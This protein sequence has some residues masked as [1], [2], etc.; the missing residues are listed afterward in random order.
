MREALPFA[1]ASFPSIQSLTRVNPTENPLRRCFRAAS[2]LALATA[3]TTAV[4]TPLLRLQGIAYPAFVPWR[5]KS[6]VPLIAMGLSAAFLQFA[7]PRT[8]RERLLGLMVGAAFLLWG[9]EQ[10]IRD[11]VAVAVI[12]DWVVLLFVAD[13]GLVVAGHIKGSRTL[14]ERR[15]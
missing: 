4:A 8:T 2:A 6:A 12:D 5:L 11:A 15:N 10:F 14:P 13:L 7:Q 3:A 1:S 9:A